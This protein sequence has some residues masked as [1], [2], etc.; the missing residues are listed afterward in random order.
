MSAKRTMFWLF[1]GALLLVG[2]G[3]AKA[4][5]DGCAWRDRLVGEWNNVATGENIVIGRG[6]LGL[7]EV[8]ASNG[9]QGRVASAEERGA[10]ILL[11]SRGGDC[12]YYAT[13]INP[14]QMSLNLR[15]GPDSCLKGIFLR[16]QKEP[17][18]VQHRVIRRVIH[19]ACCRWDP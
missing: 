4:D 16:V 13:L 18:P 17:E 9:G 5:C 12:A 19:V 1:A 6:Q 15:S 14:N 10:N 8:W 2:S 11:D 7:W 3:F